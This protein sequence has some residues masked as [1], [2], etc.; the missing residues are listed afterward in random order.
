[1][2][3]IAR[4]PLREFGE[5]HANARRPLQ[6]WYAEI[7]K[8]YWNGPDDVK[9]RYPQ[10]SILPNDRVVFNIGGNSYRLVVAMRYDIQIAY[11]R[12]MGTHGEYDKIDAQEV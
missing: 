10:A 8:A 1:M 6:A 4:R 11:V 5:R 9:R 2:R 3:L 7:T 12:F